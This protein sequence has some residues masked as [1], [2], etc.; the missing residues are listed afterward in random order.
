FFTGCNVKSSSTSSIEPKLSSIQVKVFDVSCNTVSC[1]GAE[2]KALL[3]LQ[4]GHAHESLLA[5]VEHDVAK[6]RY[7]AR[8]VPGSPD[9]SFLMKKILGPASDEGDRMPQRNAML[10]P[11]AIEA[12]RTWI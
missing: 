3:D 6:F 1:H 9:S 10:S 11:D 7:V 5:P 2:M 12:I 8:V 4:P